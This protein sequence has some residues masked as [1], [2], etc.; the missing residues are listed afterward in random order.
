ML[1]KKLRYQEGKRVSYISLIANILLAILKISVG[2][3]AGSKALIADG[4]HSV[5]DMASTLIVLIS[6]NLSETPADKDHPYGHEKAEALGTNLLA[7][8]LII[9]AVFLSRDAFLTL[10]SGEI[11]QPGFLALIVAFISIVVKELLYRYTI[12]VGKKINSRALI[13]DAHHHRSD[14]LSSIAALIGIAGA[15]MGFAVLDPLAGLV[16]AILIFK[17][18]YDILKTTSYELMD[19]RPSKEKIN[20]IYETAKTIKGVIDVSDIKIRSYGP[21]YIVDLKIVVSGRIT[22][23]QG[24]NIAS[25]VKLQIISEHDDVKDVFVHVNPNSVH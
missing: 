1:G 4:F 24:H 18:G 3:I 8:I 25:D 23:R 2:F 14:A 17:V 11:S 12:I 10:I 15:R 6:I 19:G 16:V 5:S 22:V 13:A 7:V 20:T 21:L 9:T